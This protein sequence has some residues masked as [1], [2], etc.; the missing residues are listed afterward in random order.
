[1]TV[2]MMKSIFFIS[3]RGMDGPAVILEVDNL[4]PESYRLWEC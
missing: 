3:K 1:M 2:R 4:L